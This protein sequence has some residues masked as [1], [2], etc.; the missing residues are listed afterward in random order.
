[1]EPEASGPPGLAAA[2]VNSSFDAIISKTLDGTITSWNAAAVALFGYCPE[3]VI[4]ES[5]RLI[6]TDRRDEED[7]VLA[8]IKTGERVAPYTTVRVDK[9]GRS[10]NVLLIISPICDTNQK[11]IGASE[12]ILRDAARKDALETLRESEEHLRRFVEHAPAPIRDHGEA[13]CSER[14]TSL[15]GP[16]F[17][18]PASNIEPRGR[19]DFGHGKGFDRG[20][21]SRQSRSHQSSHKERGAA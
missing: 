9:N 10:I 18:Q 19:R 4:G 20:G 15:E 3:E 16:C 6:P 21:P 14:G 7:R 13:I 1:M 12:I 5:I 2:I 17:R 8:R 11:I